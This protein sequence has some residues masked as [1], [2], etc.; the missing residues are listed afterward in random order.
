M[1]LALWAVARPAPLDDWRRAMLLGI[2]LGV[3][4]ATRAQLSM[5]I[6]V[7]LAGTFVRTRFKFA[8][9]AAAIVCAFA[10]TLLLINMR[11]FAH[12]FGAIP[13]LESL[14]PA[15]HATEGSFRLT[16]TGP[17]GLLVSPN[18]GLLI[19]S[20]VVLVALAGVPLAF[21]SGVHSPVWWCAL[22][23]LAQY[24]FYGSYTVWWGGHTYGPRYMLDVLPLLVPIAG[25]LAGSIQ[26]TRM[27]RSIAAVALGWSVLVA[28]TGAFCY[29]HERWNTD[30]NDVDRNHARLWDW[31][32]MQIAR[33]WERGVSPTNFRLLNRAAARAE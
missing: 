12:P 32:D 23:A 29:P 19:F 7:L 24:L 2:G 18:R 27:A 1:S 31:R 33:C 5:A 22:A 26:P 11:W 8:A 30:P 16:L 6:F 21:R 10:A 9:L 20:P 28:A 14:H 4:G 17:A 13:L 25:L 15:I 3:A